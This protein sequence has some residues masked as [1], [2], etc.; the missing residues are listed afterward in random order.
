MK[1]SKLFHWL[2]GLVMLLP[3]FAIGTTC[4][5]STFN[6]ASKQESEIIYKYET[7]EVNS[8]D[9][10]VVGRIY[11]YSID[12]SSLTGNLLACNSLYNFNSDKQYDIEI[13]NSFG[14]L[15]ISVNNNTSIT[16]VQRDNNFNTLFTPCIIYNINNSKFDCDVVFKGIFYSDSYSNYSISN[17]NDIPIKSVET[18]NLD[19]QDIF[20]NSIDKVC[21]SALF[22]WAYDSFLVQPFAYICALFSM[23]SNSFVVQMLS[24]WLAI[25]IIWLVFDLIMYIPLLVHRWLDKGVLE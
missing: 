18:H 9:D 11:H 16:I 23:P 7:N 21:T 3:I 12:F 15:T 20:Y 25:S 1:I 19:T 2:Y 5:I 8:V 22:S 24:Y 4:L 6:M 17:L 13:D 14:F 10:L